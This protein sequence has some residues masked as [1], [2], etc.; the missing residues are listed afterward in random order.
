MQA[1]RPRGPLSALVLSWLHGQDAP[2]VPKAC[3]LVQEASSDIICDED[4]QLTLWML[5][6]LH[7]TGF[8]DVDA[9][10]EWSPECLAV[11]RRLE[12]E[13]EDDL[14]ASTADP[15]RAVCERSGGVAERL[16]DLVARDRS[17][18]LGPYIQRHASRVE[19]IEFLIHRSIYNLKEADPHTW[20]VPRLTGAP[21][22]A[23]VELQYD[24]YG[25]G[26]AERLHAKMFAD[27]LRACQ[28]SSQ[29]GAYIDVVPA[30]TLALNNGLSMFGLHRR[31][32]AA[33][34]GHL[35]AFEAS[36]SLPSRQVAR[37]LRRLG[38][39]DPAA[40][41]FDEHVEADAVHEQVAIRN[42]CAAL[43]AQDPQSMQTVAFGA[44][45][46]LYLDAR[47][48]AYVLDAWAAGRSALLPDVTQS[49]VLGA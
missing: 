43:V 44:A 13:L 29:V 7:Y 1:P 46:C 36:S 24:E 5:Y 30:V 37:G 9:A 23:L 22:V 27:T 28:L 31:L 34:V 41:Y 48:A 17:P 33:A 19:A 49:G 45:A 38:F 25:T 15:V 16:F 2:S 21:K 32:T 10:W 14:R 12:T 6:E 35:A 8:D 4:R 26:D 47:V 42:I 18:S 11:R 20:A 39:P 3:R 40:A